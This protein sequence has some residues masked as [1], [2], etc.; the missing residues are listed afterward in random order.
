MA[1]PADVFYMGP[2][3][4]VDAMTPTQE[5]WLELAAQEG[6]ETDGGLYLMTRER[7]IKFAQAAFKLGEIDMRERAS[8]K[9]LELAKLCE[10]MQNPK[11]TSQRNYHLMADAQSYRNTAAKIR[12]LKTRNE[13]TQERE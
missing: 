7:M 4:M 6:F 11:D 9:C 13:E 3:T 8:D 2:K 5:Q 1:D 10:D 12:R